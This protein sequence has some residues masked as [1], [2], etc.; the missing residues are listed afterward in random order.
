MMAKYKPKI[1]HPKALKYRKDIEN[2]IRE[3]IQNN[4]TIVAILDSISHMAEAP[5][6]SSGLYKIYGDVIEEERY[7]NQVEIGH[8]LRRKIQEGDSKLIEFLAKTKMGL[9][10]VQ[11]VKEIDDEEENKDAVS[12]LAQLLGKDTEPEDK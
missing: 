9:N 1:N 3:G 7:K 12:R 8:A 2:R 11:Q 4:L 10:P 5:Q 6:N